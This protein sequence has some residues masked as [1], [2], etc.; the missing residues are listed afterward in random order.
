M[1]PEFQS[2]IFARRAMGKR[3][4]VI[5]NVVEEVNLILWK[6]KA[7][8]NGMDRRVAPSLVE[9]TAIFVERFKEIQIRLRSEPIEVADFKVGPLETTLEI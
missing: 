1:T 3:N 2:E 8:G 5:R 6:K 9:E 7:G 4:M